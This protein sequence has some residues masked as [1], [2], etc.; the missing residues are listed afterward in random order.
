[1]FGGSSVLLDGLVD[2]T[3]ADVQISE[4][5]GAVPI[6]G[7]LLY[8]KAV[9]FDRLRDAVLTN[10]F[11]DL[12]QCLFTIECHRSSGGGSQPIV[13]NSSGSVGGQNERRCTVE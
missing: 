3:R 2:E 6:G 10:V 5:V 8:D 9:P 7:I 11:F 1:M 4:D 13:S 12:S